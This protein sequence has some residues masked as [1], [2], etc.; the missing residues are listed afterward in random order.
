MKK[1]TKKAVASDR[2]ERLKTGGGSFIPAVNDMDIKL[3]GL[4]GNRAT[5]LPNAFDS[6]AA[7]HS[8]NTS[9]YFYV[10]IS[11]TR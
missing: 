8:D 6:D 5:P 7:Y 3:L 9:M 4:L 1:R 11:W 10:A 2:V